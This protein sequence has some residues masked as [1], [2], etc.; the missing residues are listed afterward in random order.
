MVRAV[1]HRKGS[2]E[3]VGSPGLEIFTTQLDKAPSNLI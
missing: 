2:R 1:K 3:V